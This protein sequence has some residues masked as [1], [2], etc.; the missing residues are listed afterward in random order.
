MLSSYV[1]D[2]FY[3]FMQKRIFGCDRVPLFVKKKIKEKIAFKSRHYILNNKPD[4]IQLTKEI[5]I[6]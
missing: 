4:Y 6:T 3:D 5:V 2:L 1:S